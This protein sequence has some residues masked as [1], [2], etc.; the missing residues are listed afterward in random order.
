MDPNILKFP[1]I[2]LHDEDWRMSPYLKNLYFYVIH[3]WGGVYLSIFHWVLINP[4]WSLVLTRKERALYFINLQTYQNLMCSS[5]MKNGEKNKAKNHKSFSTRRHSSLIPKRN[6]FPHILFEFNFWSSSRPIPRISQ[7]EGGKDTT[8]W[9]K[10]HDQSGRCAHKNKREKY[11][12]VTYHLD[13]RVSVFCHERSI[14][15][16]LEVSESSFPC[17]Y[18]TWKC[19]QEKLMLYERHAGSAFQF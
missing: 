2:W 4:S 5:L 6:S 3:L 7:E 12:Q 1:Q 8:T 14:G 13:T 16:L 19:N 15:K 11:C 17:Y 9:I 18:K 10:P